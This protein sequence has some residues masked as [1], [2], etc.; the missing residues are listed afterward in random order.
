LDIYGSSNVY[1]VFATLVESEV[2]GAYS[3]IWP[4]RNGD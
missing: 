2:V 3:L 4:R 1:G